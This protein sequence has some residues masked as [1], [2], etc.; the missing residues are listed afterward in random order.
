MDDVSSTNNDIPKEN[1]NLYQGDSCDNKPLIIEKEE[2]VTIYQTNNE[3]S[4]MGTIVGTVVP[5]LLEEQEDP[6]LMNSILLVVD[7]PS[8][9]PSNSIEK[10][11]KSRNNQI[12]MECPICLETMDHNI[13]TFI[14]S[15]Q[16]C[17]ECVKK[18]R[19]YKQRKCPLCRGPGINTDDINPPPSSNMSDE[20]VLSYRERRIMAI[21]A[22]LDRIEQSN[23]TR[24]QLRR[25]IREEQRQQRDANL[26]KW[27]TCSFVSGIGLV[28]CCLLHSNPIT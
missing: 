26:A 7:E 16:F 19:E 13:I 2:D 6:V 11:D 4:V 5:G 17:K 25:R 18:L 22:S 12:I 10:T 14:C 24:A 21:Q 3:E 23:R 9:D 15:H 20:E 1:T 27:N 8:L 28:I